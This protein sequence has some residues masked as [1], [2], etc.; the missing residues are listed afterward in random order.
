MIT[1]AVLAIVATLVL[2]SVSS[3]ESLSLVSAA[4]ILASDLEYAQSE[5]LTNPADPT[6]VVVDAAQRRYMLALES[7]LLTPIGR[8]EA[9]PTA[10]VPD[11]YQVVFGEGELNFISSVDIE[12]V[13]GP[14]GSVPF[15]AY[16]RL[17]QPENV[18]IRLWNDSGELFVVISATTT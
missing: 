2:P 11:P 7:D 6:Y 17:S 16:G 15:D 13:S 14:S 9:G 10:G 4:N 1:L 12:M 8:P 5:S 18:R 3:N